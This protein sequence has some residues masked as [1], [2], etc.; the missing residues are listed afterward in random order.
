MFD[1]TSPE[2]APEQ[3]PEQSMSDAWLTYAQAGE[4]FGLTADAMRMR[5]RRLGWRTQPGNDGRTLL[6]VPADVV[7]EPRLR[8]PEGS[9][10]R[11]TEGPAERNEVVERFLDRLEAGDARAERAEQRAERA[12]Q[13]TEQ[14]EQRADRNAAQLSE[15][16]VRADRLRET[17]DTTYADLIAARDQA[18]QAAGRA[19]AAESEAD[20]LRQAE[21]ERKARGLIARLRNAW[22]GE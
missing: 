6:L 14:A 21:A 5:A 15:E 1:R 2:R 9:P 4:R 8:S 11:A 12:E 18:R 22:Q 19:E 10:E 20:R 7:V 17:L 13:K 16:R 3:R